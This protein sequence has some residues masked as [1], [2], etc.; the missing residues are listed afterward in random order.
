MT[1]TPPTKSTKPA[2]TS[3]INQRHGIKFKW[4]Q[5][6]WAKEGRSDIIVFEQMTTEWYKAKVNQM[7]AHIGKQGGLHPARFDYTYKVWYFAQSS[8]QQYYAKMLSDTPH[9]VLRYRDLKCF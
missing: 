1:K 2:V 5:R 8:L 6:P 3:A 7:K 4:L 9:W